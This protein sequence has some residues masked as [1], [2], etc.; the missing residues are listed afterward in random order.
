MI[1][2]WWECKRLTEILQKRSRDR[3][4][5]TDK[6]DQGWY[7]ICFVRMC[8]LNCFPLENALVGPWNRFPPAKKTKK[9]ESVFNFVFLFSLFFFFFFFFFHLSYDFQLKSSFLILH[10]FFP[11][12][13]RIFLSLALEVFKYESAI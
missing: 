5:N 3:K 1:L 7:R 10:F 9:S 2:I 13:K 8:I 4:K 12:T 6:K 11:V